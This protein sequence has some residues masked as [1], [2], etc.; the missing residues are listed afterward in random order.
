[1]LGTV[2]TVKAALVEHEDEVLDELVELLAMLGA[3][4]EWT[5]E[6]NFRTAERVASLSRK[7]GLPD[8]YDQDSGALSFWR[9]VA[10]EANVY[11]YYEDYV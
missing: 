5:M 4:A 7:I 11:Y 10:D 9:E 3:H 1:M 2:E 6:H 8:A